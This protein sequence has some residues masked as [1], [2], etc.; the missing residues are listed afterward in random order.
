[1]PTGYFHIAFEAIIAV[2]AIAAGA[3]ASV[4]GFGIGSILTPL[5]ASQYGMK[6]AVSLVAVP[7]A[8]AS[9]LR[10]WQMRKLVDRRALCGFGL[11][12]ALGALIGALVHIRVTSPF[13]T[14]LLGA[15]LICAGVLGVTG[16][17]EKLRLGR[18]TS[19]V[20]GALSGAFGGLVGNQGGIRSAAM[21]ELQLDR[22]A[23]VATATAIALGVDAV[24]LPVYLATGWQ[25]ILNAWPAILSATSGVILGTLLGVR[26]LRRIPEPI[27]RKIVSLLLLAIGV[28]LLVRSF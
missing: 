25:Q 5:I 16:F 26:V 8:I 19:W 15:L 21:L 22:D 9:L 18:R 24:R 7:H 1:V 2:I 14:V 28:G 23:F 27:F 4:A 3:T 12:N 6:T 11:A 10:F 13:L 17:A 20:L